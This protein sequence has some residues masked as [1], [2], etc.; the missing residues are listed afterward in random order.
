M[1]KI[2]IVFAALFSFVQAAEE[3]LSDAEL[4]NTIKSIEKRE[5][6]AY[7]ILN[8]EQDLDDRVLVFPTNRL[9]DVTST[10][11]DRMCTYKTA[12]ITV[13]VVF[14]CLFIASFCWAGYMEYLKW[15]VL[16]NLANSNVTIAVT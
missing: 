3:N 7:E 12:V 2:I 15:K 1:K 13:G 6:R 10:L 9:Q 16:D 4:G 14:A 8:E 11:R 5:H